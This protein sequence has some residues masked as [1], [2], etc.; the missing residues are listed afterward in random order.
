MTTE[1]IVSW[2]ALVAIIVVFV[3]YLRMSEDQK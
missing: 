3:F 2:I 1:D